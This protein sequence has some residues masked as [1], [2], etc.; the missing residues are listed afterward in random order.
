MPNTIALNSLFTAQGV[1]QDNAKS[2][3]EQL[4]SMSSKLQ[5]AA[6]DIQSAYGIVSR[7]NEAQKKARQEKGLAMLLERAPILAA[8]EQADPDM[9]VAFPQLSRVVAAAIAAYR[10]GDGLALRVTDK[11][12]RN[13]ANGND[14]YQVAFEFTASEGN[15]LAV[16]TL[17]EIQ[18]ECIELSSDD[19][20]HWVHVNGAPLERADRDII[21]DALYDAAEGI[22][23]TDIDFVAMPNRDEIDQAKAMLSKY[24][25]LL[26]AVAAQ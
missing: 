2:P 10:E 17:V 18:G 25:N 14:H 9:A 22:F 7:F 16:I 6:D 24:A 15:A 8:F 21:R 20:T 23:T 12:V 4:E 5:R 26:S 11:Y 3:L 1:S 13:D 19:R